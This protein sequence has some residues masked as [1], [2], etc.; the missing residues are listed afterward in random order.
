[1]STKKLFRKD[2]RLWSSI[3][4]DGVERAPSRAMLRAVGFKDAD[5]KKPQIGIAS[6]W[7]MV[8]PCNMH[9]DRLARESEKGV[10]V[11]NGKAVLFNT[12]SISD[13]ISMGTEGMKYSLVS[14]EVIAD[15]IETLQALLVAER[16]RLKGLQE[17]AGRWAAAEDLAR[18]EARPDFNLSL[19]YRQR[20]F[21][22]G[23]PVKGSDF[24]S[25]YLRW[26]I[27]P[28]G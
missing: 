27:H 13:G 19:G 20:D 2:Q 28:V 14:R 15:S 1:M 11:S 5:F 16:P 24:L 3:V 8:T 21:M 7:S 9:M 22:A 26:S 23:D 18:R 10:D 6:T 25:L 17:E 12:I 4:V